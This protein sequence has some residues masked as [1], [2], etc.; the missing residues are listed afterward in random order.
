LKR[1]DPV[2]VE[3]TVVEVP[4]PH[5]TFIWQLRHLSPSK[6]RSVDLKQS[7]ALILRS[8]I[9]VGIFKLQ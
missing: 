7:A 4:M 5:Q 3:S 8:I 2:E 6:E 9:G 1:W